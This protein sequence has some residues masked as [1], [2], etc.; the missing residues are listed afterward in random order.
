MRA[1]V[2]PWS[3][4]GAIAYTE[5]ATFQDC[6]KAFALMGACYKARDGFFYNEFGQRVVIVWLDDNEI[7][8]NHIAES[9]RT[10]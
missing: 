6:R 10:R 8:E 5:A 3:S 7:T 1:K 4:G 2:L 9:E